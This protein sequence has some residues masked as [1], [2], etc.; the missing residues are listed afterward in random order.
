LETYFGT[1][2]ELLEQLKSYLGSNKTILVL[3]ENTDCYLK[4]FQDVFG[5][6]FTFLKLKSGEENKNLNSISKIWDFL[7][8]NNINRNDT[9]L[10]LGGG[11]VGDIASFAAATYKRGIDFILFPTTLLSMVDSSIGGKTGFNFNHLKN[12]IG[13]FNTPKAVFYSSEFLKTL[14]ENEI[15]SGLAEVYKHSII[16][17]KETW[18][19]LKNTTSGLNYEYLTKSSFLL[20]SKIVAE[21][22]LEKSSRKK[23][24]FGH[25]VGHAIE[26]YLLTK[27][28]PVLHGIAIAK[29]IIIE[30]YI[31]Y[32]QKLLSEKD[33]KTIETEINIKFKKFFNFKIKLI[34]VLNLMKFDKKN[35]SNTINFS[36]PTTI[37]NVIVNQEIS[38]E[39][40]ADYLK[41]YFSND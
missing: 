24:N 6:D 36:L 21:D 17:D 23:L 4:D 18:N 9:L 39:K 7:N 1:I 41:R 30:S 37:G 11:M 22:P 35:T 10:I 29:G 15:Y 26:S 3:D 40:V 14:P 8:T 32:K 28:T 5:V 2:K 38:Q 27:K 13:T 16:E 19:Y 25:T 34:D 12:N 20:K 33:F 31:A